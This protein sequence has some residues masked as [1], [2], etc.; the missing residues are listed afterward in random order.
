[1]EAGTRKYEG[2][3]ECMA[4]AAVP[5]VLGQPNGACDAVI[6]LSLSE[7]LFC[8]DQIEIFSIP[9]ENSGHLTIFCGE[10][11]L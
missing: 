2:T 3:Y 10:F 4:V 9:R 1:M 7:M 11:D 8:A 5:A 6:S